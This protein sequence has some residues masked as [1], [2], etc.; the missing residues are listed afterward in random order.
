[1][2]L[3]LQ[4]Q[5]KIKILKSMQAERRKVETLFKILFKFNVV[6]IH[7]IHFY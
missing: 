1:M 5:E 7:L 3:Y 4:R 2:Q 6:F